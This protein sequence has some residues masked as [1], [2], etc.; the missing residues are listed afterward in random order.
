MA[1]TPLP[2]AGT[3]ALRVLPPAPA[4]PTGAHRPGEAEHR[5][6]LLAP[7]YQRLTSS[8]THTGASAAAPPG[9][10]AVVDVA[11]AS[12]DWTQL[13][14][15]LRAL[16][17]RFPCCPIVLQLDPALDDLL[18]VVA[19][20]SRLPV[21]AVLMRGAALPPVLRRYMTQPACLADDVLEWLQ[22]RGIRMSPALAYL[23]W[24]IF[25]RAPF[26]PDLSGL[27]REIGVVESSARF[28][29]HKKSLP[30][31]SRWLQA[32]RA[33]HA[34]LRLQAEPERPLLRLALELGYSDHSALSH[35]IHRTFG[36]RA[37]AIRDTLGW[38]W[39]LERWLTTARETS[40]R[41]RRQ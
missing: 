11:G 5:A 4:A 40:R 35:Q 16:R 6:W 20:A 14:G 1:A 30:A 26:H 3:P 24:Q 25:A 10:L 12:V 28:R 7:P 18:F 9:T 29:F 38:E 33:L 13:E 17:L 32:A 2:V 19:R 41:G 21:R 22:M 15:D 37:G 39:L 23:V 34:A 8:T 27:C 31:P 36:V